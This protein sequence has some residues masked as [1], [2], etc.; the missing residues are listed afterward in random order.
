M[1][2]GLHAYRRSIEYDNRFSH[3]PYICVH[4]ISQ[5]TGFVAAVNLEIDNKPVPQW[6]TGCVQSEEHP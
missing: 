3:D 6:A 5:I 1:R 4:L 2:S